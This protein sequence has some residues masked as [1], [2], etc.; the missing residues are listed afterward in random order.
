MVSFVIKNQINSTFEIVDLQETNRTVINNPFFGTMYK[1]TESSNFENGT[2]IGTFFGT[3]Y[4]LYVGANHRNVGTLLFGHGIFSTCLWWTM[5]ESI[6]TMLGQCFNSR[7]II[8]G[9]QRYSNKLE[10]NFG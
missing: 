8:N 10:T 5:D 1:L 4:Q 3:E 2:K 7:A 9:F 6:Q